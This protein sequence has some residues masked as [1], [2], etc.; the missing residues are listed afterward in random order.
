MTNLFLYSITRR[1]PCQERG[2]EEMEQNSHMANGP[3]SKA[4]D[5][6]PSMTSRFRGVLDSLSLLALPVIMCY[7]LFGGPSLHLH[8]IAY[9]ESMATYYTDRAIICGSWDD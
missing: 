9:F 5:I 4:L 8:M 3:R 7:F 2:R 6:S 1:L